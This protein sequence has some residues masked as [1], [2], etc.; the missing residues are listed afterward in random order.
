M[1]FEDEST[2]DVVFALEPT[3]A[4]S[5]ASFS[6]KEGCSYKF[7]L[8]FRVQHEIVTG[9][10]FRNKVKK[11]MFSDTE[12][13]MLGSY[14]PQTAPHSF[15]MPRHGWEQAPKGMLARGKYKA[16][17]KFVDSDGVEHA[18]FGYQFTIERA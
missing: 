12:E 16:T 4:M 14:A 10:K 7:Q 13:L 18:Q 9:L 3:A 5:G 6:M 1:L 15:L 2:E 8:S 11:S 17:A